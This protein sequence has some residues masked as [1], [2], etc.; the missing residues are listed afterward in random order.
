MSFGCRCCF[1]WPELV[2][3]SIAVL[4]RADGWRRRVILGGVSAE[5]V[6]KRTLGEEEDQK[7]EK[8]Q[9]RNRRMG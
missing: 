2:G 8:N 1:L 7:E 3:G 6:K 9:K 5:G 4:A